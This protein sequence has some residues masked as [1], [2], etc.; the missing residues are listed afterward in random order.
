[1][2]EFKIK[3]DSQ[4]VLTFV[5]LCFGATFLGLY[6]GSEFMYTYFETYRADLWQPVTYLR[7]ITY[8]FGHDSW[9]MLF[10]NSLYLLLLGP[11]LE[12]RYGSQVM[13]VM[14]AVTAISTSLLNFIFFPGAV[15]YGS[16]GIVLAFIILTA[17]SGL[18]EGYF[19][20][21]LALIAIV[22]FRQEILQNVI[23]VENMANVAPIIGCILGVG[24]A[25]AMVRK[26]A[27]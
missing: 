21:S 12:K 1:M 9:D 2:G 27:D 18:T 20:V 11:M 16:N 19:P 4:V 7:F 8:I 15:L 14:I 10:E 3:Y 13:V 17:I 6:Y 24:V 23:R 5:L 26:D 22:F 25:F